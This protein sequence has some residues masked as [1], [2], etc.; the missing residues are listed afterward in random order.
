MT[1][2][3][4][5]QSQIKAF[6]EEVRLHG[7]PASRRLLVPGVPPAHSAR[8]DPPARRRCAEAGGTPALHAAALPPQSAWRPLQVATEVLTEGCPGLGQYPKSQCEADYDLVS[9]SGDDL[10]FG[11][12]P[13]DNDMCSA[14]KRPK[15]LA[16][17][18]S[19]RVK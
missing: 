9:V 17:F 5:L 14:D 8:S 7:A 11:S 3:I 2:R 15:A 4:V 12:R 19:H 6:L 1:P 18:A 10:R 13:A 16:A